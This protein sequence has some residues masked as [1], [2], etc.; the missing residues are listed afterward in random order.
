MKSGNHRKREYE[1]ER[2]GE[3]ERET[4]GEGETD[5]ASTESPSTPH[6]EDA[7]LD[8]QVLVGGVEPGELRDTARERRDEGHVRRQVAEVDVAQLRSRPQ[9]AHLPITRS[10]KH[11]SLVRPEM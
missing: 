3:R 6:L 11:R 9:H 4:D 7:R 1:R 5:R 10:T 2:E 8:E